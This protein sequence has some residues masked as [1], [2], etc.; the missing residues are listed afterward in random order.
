MVT[1]QESPQGPGE[2]TLLKADSPSLPLSPCGY[3]LP[4]TGAP[5][6]AIGGALYLGLAVT[7][8]SQV[9]LAFGLQSE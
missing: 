5:A 3:V 2:R 7:V 6:V 1:E 9:A 8:R 4:I